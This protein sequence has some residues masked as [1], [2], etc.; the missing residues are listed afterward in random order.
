MCKVGSAGYLGKDTSS[1]GLA[2][3]AV[4]SPSEFLRGEEIMELVFVMGIVRCLVR[5][6]FESEG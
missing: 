4:H 5:Y 1:L 3:M 6:M 2:V